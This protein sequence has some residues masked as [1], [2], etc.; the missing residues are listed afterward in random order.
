MFHSSLQW[1]KNRICKADQKA[2]NQKHY[3]KFKAPLYKI[4]IV[5]TLRDS[6]ILSLRSL[7]ELVIREKRFQ[8]LIV[9]VSLVDTR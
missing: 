7:R 2:N 4:H 6:L 8:N 5:R 3:K 1:L 9:G